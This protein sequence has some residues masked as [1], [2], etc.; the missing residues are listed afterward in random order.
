MRK[1]ILCATI[2]LDG[3]LAP[4]YG[5]FE[6]IESVSRQCN[7]KTSLIHF[8]SVDTII[9]GGN[10]YWEFICK[11]VDIPF[12]DKKVYVVSKNPLELHRE[13]IYIKEN[14]IN[15]IAK[16]KEEDGK[17]IWLIGGGLLTISLMEYKLID[18]MVINYL[19]VMLGEGILLFPRFKGE[20]KWKLINSRPFENKI[21]QVEYDLI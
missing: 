16:L 5:G 6:I 20:S 19:P 13:I 17:D 18:K 9:M 10:T 12:R 15:K 2:S 4:V 7:L 21:L 8:N 11:R 3:Y 14:A 1:I